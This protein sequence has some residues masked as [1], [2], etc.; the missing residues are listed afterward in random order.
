MVVARQRPSFERRKHVRS[1][2]AVHGSAL[3]ARKCYTPE[4]NVVGLLQPSARQFDRLSVVWYMIIMQLSKVMDAGLNVAI[5]SLTL[6]CFSKG[7]A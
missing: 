3:Y 2:E 1:C 5:R 7:T 4:L 6:S